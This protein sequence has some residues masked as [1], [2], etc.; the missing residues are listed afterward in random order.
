MYVREGRNGNVYGRESECY[1]K[2]RE[3]LLARQLSDELL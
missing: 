3:V 1:T 2:G